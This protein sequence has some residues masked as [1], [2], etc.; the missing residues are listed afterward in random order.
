MAPGGVAGAAAAA[1]AAD[2][3]RPEFVATAFLRWLSSSNIETAL[4]GKPWQN[5]LGESFSGKFRDECLS[6]EWFRNRTDAKIVI[7]AW[8]PSSK[9]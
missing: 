4:I 3:N 5:A 1:P 9:F 6:M 7:E 2:F 8:R